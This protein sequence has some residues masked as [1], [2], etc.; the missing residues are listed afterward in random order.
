MNYTKAAEELDKVC[1]RSDNVCIERLIYPKSIE[2]FKHTCVFEGSDGRRYRLRPPKFYDRHCLGHGVSTAERLGGLD[3]FHNYTIWTMGTEQDKRGNVAHL[4]Y[5]AK[6]K[7]M[8]FTKELF[9][10]MVDG[11]ESIMKLANPPPEDKCTWTF[12][13]KLILKKKE[14]KPSWINKLFSTT[15]YFKMRL[16]SRIFRLFPQHEILKMSS[17]KFKEFSMRIM[18]ATGEDEARALITSMTFPWLKKSPSDPSLDLNGI[19]ALGRYYNFPMTSG[20]GEANWLEL[21]TCIELYGKALQQNKRNGHTFARLPQLASAYISAIHYDQYTKPTVWHLLG[22]PPNRNCREVEKKM[23][24]LTTLARKLEII[25]IVPER[26][27]RKNKRTPKNMQRVIYC[28]DDWIMQQHVTRKMNELADNWDVRVDADGCRS[29]DDVVRKIEAG[30]PP[31]FEDV[32]PM[33]H[34][35]AFQKTWRERLDPMQKRAVANAVLNP[36]PFVVGRPGTGKTEFFRAISQLFGAEGVVGLAAYGRIANVMRDRIGASY[37]FHRAEALVVHKPSSADSKL[38]QNS[39]TICVDEFGLITHEHLSR[40]FYCTGGRKRRLI[41][42]GDGHQMGA[43]GSGSIVHSIYDCFSNRPDVFTELNIPHRF[44]PNGGIGMSAEEIQ[45]AIVNKPKDPT[46]PLAAAWNMKQVRDYKAGRGRLDLVYGTSADARFIIIPESQKGEKETIRRLRKIGVE[47]KG[48]LARNVQI[49]AHTNRTKDMVNCAARTLISNPPYDKHEFACREKITFS[50]NKYLEESEEQE[51]EEAAEND[52]NDE[53]GAHSGRR[54]G[55]RP[56][57]RGAVGSGGGMEAQGDIIMDFGAL[58]RG[59]VKRHRPDE[60]FDEASESGVPH[61][62]KRQRASSAGRDSGGEV[63]SSKNSKKPKR[64][65]D[66]NWRGTDSDNVFNGD[67]RTIDRICEVNQRGYITSDVA[68][69]DSPA[70][71][72]TSRL[73][74]FDDGTQLFLKDYEKHL[75]ESAICTTS[76][77]FQG[78]EVETAINRHKPSPFVRRDQ[79]YT[80]MTRGIKRF[81]W[82][83]GDTIDNA[84]IDIESIAAA[85]PPPRRENFACYLNF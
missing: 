20:L 6:P 8:H 67:I 85:D 45:S 54:S 5:Y 56:T 4:I 35:P 41:M 16:S 64:P 44:L 11:C 66:R 65:R 10:R 55:R 57:R 1:E 21:I 2:E 81:V 83:G 3:L 84:L 48:L 31:A 72:N 18:E 36:I 29:Y 60:T 75:I 46:S 69:T 24:E 23:S 39:H 74:L 15:P 38:I 53:G 30:R 78:S 63:K 28:M 80:N 26:I 79:L 33:W 58:R 22:E 17:S 12:M 68:R 76:K 52:S 50:T 70:T 61:S 19:L 43:I 40:M 14:D 51:E 13:R 9:Q 77:G 82:L 59:G 73:I 27:V 49:L 62:H 42:A 37:T 47:G 32:G 7:A 34:S 25:K 71:S